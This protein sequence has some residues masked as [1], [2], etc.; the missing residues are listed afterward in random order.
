MTLIIS[1][2]AIKN[3]FVIASSIV[4][5]VVTINKKKDSS[6]EGKKNTK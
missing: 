1:L 6:Q 2:E 5:I 3:L 4:T